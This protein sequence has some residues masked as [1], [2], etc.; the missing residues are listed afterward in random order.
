MSKNPDMLTVSEAAELL[1]RH[2]HTI[3]KLI[4]SGV[5]PAKQLG[6]NG[7]F[8][9]SKAALLDALEYDP[10]ADERRQSQE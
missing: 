9:V 4:K 8:L 5:V 1:G 10:T 3:R 2:P 7:M 6:K